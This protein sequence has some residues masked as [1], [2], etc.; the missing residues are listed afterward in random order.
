MYVCG[1]GP[2]LSLYDRHASGTTN[3]GETQHKTLSREEEVR[4]FREF[5][6]LSNAFADI[7]S[8]AQT[9]SVIFE[10]QFSG[11][12][13][14]VIQSSQSDEKEE[15]QE[16][17]EDR[18]L[19]LARALQAI[20]E[21]AYKAMK[22][23]EE[24]DERLARTLQAQE[25]E[26]GPPRSGAGR[27]S[28]DTDLR[29]QKRKREEEEEDLAKS[30]QSDEAKLRRLEGT[31]ELTNDEIIVKM[32]QEEEDEIY[33][34]EREKKAREE[35]EQSRKLIEALRREEDLEHDEWVRSE[36][37][38]IEA[39]E[40]SD[41][42]WPGFGFGWGDKERMREKRTGTIKGDYDWKS[43]KFFPDIT[44]LEEFLQ[45]CARFSGTCCP[46]V[47]LHLHTRPNRDRFRYHHQCHEA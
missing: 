10:G 19:V 18:D 2:D 4:K 37:A 42:K 29:S 36:L 17:E 7:F 1:H 5:T 3:K 20:E 28:K 12:K 47:Y 27:Q 34:R 15:G 25:R 46:I 9:G 35:E 32:L 21:D 23:M 45:S 26:G 39:R 24:E 13:G 6:D 31:E 44:I 40:K 14:K 43:S 8:G 30:M 38:N 33:K 11:S 22:R 16:V 41:K